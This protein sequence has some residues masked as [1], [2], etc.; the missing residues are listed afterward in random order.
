MMSRTLTRSIAAGAAALA[1]TVGAYA[2]GNASSSSGAP[3]TAMAAQAPAAT[4]TPRA[5][6]GPRAGQA[7]RAAPAPQTGQV[8]QGW[9]PGTGTIITGAT[10]DKATAAARTTYPAGT[11]NRVLRLSDGSY[12]VHIIGTAGPHHVFVSQAFKITGTA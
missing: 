2:I 7:P 3:G 12:A 9:Q 4:Q 11:V 5:G 10:A 6:F 8:P 1:L